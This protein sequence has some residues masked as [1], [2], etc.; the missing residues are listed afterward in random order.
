MNEQEERLRR[1]V[2]SGDKDAVA[3]LQRLQGRSGSNLLYHALR[4]ASLGLHVLP[5]QSQG[6]KPLNGFRLDLATTD[7]NK[8][9]S[10]WTKYPDASVGIRPSTRQIVVDVDGAGG[11]QIAQN[12]EHETPRTWMAVTSDGVHMWFRLPAC[13]PESRNGSR[14]AVVG[15]LPGGLD[16]RTNEGHV[17]APPSIHASGCVYSW[18]TAPWECS[19]AIAPSWLLCLLFGGWPPPRLEDLGSGVD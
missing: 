19:P 7:A 8:I 16:V 11:R 9:T 3:E 18:R 10:W 6:K 1:L 14:F 4:Y 17:V 2:D 15:N 13:C 12:H 5:V